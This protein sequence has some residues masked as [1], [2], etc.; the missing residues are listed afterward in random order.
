MRVRRDIEPV[1]ALKT[2]AARLLRTVNETRRPVV[3]TQSGKPKGV[4]LD[5]ESYE[6]LREATLLLK[7]IAQG[8]A[9]VRAGRTAS[10]DE[11][12]AAARARLFSR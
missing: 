9:D 4:L 3:I 10:Q 7:L 8:E 1:T 2:G 5:F 6:E 11:V 12:F